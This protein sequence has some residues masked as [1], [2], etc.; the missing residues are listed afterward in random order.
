[1]LWAGRVELV[2]E[3]CD[4]LTEPVVHWFVESVS[5]AVRAEFN[6]FI[7]AGDL[8]KAVERINE[9]T[10]AGFSAG[11]AVAQVTRARSASEELVSGGGVRENVTTHREV[12]HTGRL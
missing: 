10:P 11:A 3:T 12:R 8:K 4:W 1:M 9:M 2:R 6:R 5:Q 7:A